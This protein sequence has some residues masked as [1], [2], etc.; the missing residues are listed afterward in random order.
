[1]QQHHS[2]IGN[3]A[4]NGSIAGSARSSKID[5]QNRTPT[6][7]DKFVVDPYQNQ[8]FGAK[9]FSG[10]GVIN[11]SKNTSARKP[12]FSCKNP[13]IKNDLGEENLSASA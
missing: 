11:E 1:M 3:I 4:V 10:Q 9:N 8:S 13:P 12:I 7:N 5:G 2:T 6:E